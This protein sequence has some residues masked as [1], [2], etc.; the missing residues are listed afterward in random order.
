MKKGLGLGWWVGSPRPLGPRLGLGGGSKGFG[1]GKIG[2]RGTDP[3]AE[4]ISQLASF[5]LKRRN[6]AFFEG[7]PVGWGRV[8]GLGGGPRALVPGG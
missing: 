7:C 1:A 3:G 8:Q 2:G 5:F 6:M 4:Q